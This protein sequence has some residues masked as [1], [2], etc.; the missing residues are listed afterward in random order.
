M[1]GNLSL[2][3]VIKEPSGRKQHL[4][5]GNETPKLNLMFY[6]RKYT[7]KLYMGAR[8]EWV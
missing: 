7:L 6:I 8:V 1:E 3:E 5:M 4:K 2:A